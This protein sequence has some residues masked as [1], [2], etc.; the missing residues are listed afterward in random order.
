[1]PPSFAEVSELN[2]FVNTDVPEGTARLL[3]E[4]VTAEVQGY[5]GQTISAVTGDVV[6]LLPVGETVLFLPELPV[7][8]VATVVV[9]GTALVVTDDYM[10]TPA[11]VLTRR[12][13]NWGVIP[14]SVVVTYSHGYAE[15][16]GD[17][18]LVCLQ[19]AA[20]ALENPSGAVS[21]QVDGDYAV[22]YPHVAASAGAQ[23]HLLEDERR[24]LNRY[25]P[26]VLA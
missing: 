9:D 22:T 19:A 6:T 21:E 15:I 17:I 1:M 11:G 16:P 10:W 8:A 3:L 13:N 7:T 24:V 14:S 25:R 12:S 20:R 26:V 18:K 2:D 4:L 5:T 23:L